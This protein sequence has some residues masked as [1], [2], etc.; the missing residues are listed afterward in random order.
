M[1]I[2]V[3]CAQKSLQNIIIASSSIHP[4]CPHPPA[5]SSV[6]VSLHELF[7]RVLTNDDRLRET[8]IEKQTAQ[9][10]QRHEKFPLPFH[11]CRVSSTS[12]SL[13]IT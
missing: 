9:A 5:S 1:K 11:V 8:R 6:C 4:A 3:A 2:F 13:I 10:E 7:N 12:F